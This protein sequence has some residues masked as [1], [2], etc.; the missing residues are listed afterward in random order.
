MQSLFTKTSDLNCSP[1]RVVNRN[2]VWQFVAWRLIRWCWLKWT[3]LG[4]NINTTKIQDR[5]ERKLFR[6]A[7]ISLCVSVS[8]SVRLFSQHCWYACCCRC[9]PEDFQLCCFQLKPLCSIKG[10]ARTCENHNCF[11]PLV[12][13][14][15]LVQPLQ[16][17]DS[18][19]IYFVCVSVCTSMRVCAF[20]C[21]YVCVC[22]YVCMCMCVFCNCSYT[23]N[24]LLRPA[25]QCEHLDIC[26]RHIT[27]HWQNDCLVSV[28]KLV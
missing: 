4:W 7:Y 8:A 24:C 9:Y 21:E 15:L 25:G 16:C 26:L 6:T 14:Q 10:G 22:V 20:V 3:K 2:G 27:H 11:H 18:M 1:R 13:C 17:S 12:K 5:L 23:G 28:M 19:C